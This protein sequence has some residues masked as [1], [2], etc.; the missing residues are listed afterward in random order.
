MKESI[1]IGADVVALFCRLQMNIKRDIPIRPS[2][3]GAL[4]YIQ[5]HREPTTPLMI[6]DFFQIT[7]PSVTAII[8]ALL[9]KGYLI[10]TPS[11]K[12]G[13]SYRVSISSKGYE[14]VKSTKD[15]YFKAIELL[16]EKMGPENYG[17]FI[18]SLQQANKILSEVK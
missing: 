6:S 12:D 10:K 7:K 9:K 8:N 1:M 16:E 18:Q 17:I 13:R 4:I 14:L 3:M 2:E 5:Q 15:E 11:P